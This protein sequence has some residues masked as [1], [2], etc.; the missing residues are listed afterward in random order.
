MSSGAP[1]FLAR[2]GPGVEAVRSA[3]RREGG[4]G[5]GQQP[6]RRT[7]P[8]RRATPVSARTAQRR[9]GRLGCWPPVSPGTRRPA[10]RHPAHGRGGCEVLPDLT[11]PGCEAPQP[12]PDGVGIQTQ[13][14]RDAAVTG[15]GCLGDPGF[16][17]RLGQIAAAQE[18]QHWHQDMRRAA[19]PTDRTP[20]PPSQRN[21]AWP[22]ASTGRTPTGPTG[23]D[24]TGTPT[25][26]RPARPRPLPRRSPP[27]APLRSAP[28]GGSPLRQREFHVAR[29]ADGGDVE[30]S[31]RRSRPCRSGRPP[32][33]PERRA[34]ADTADA[35]RRGTARILAVRPRRP[36]EGQPGRR[37]GRL[38]QSG[39]VPPRQLK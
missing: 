16:T 4:P 11:G 13:P 28:P 36:P 18:P 35:G 23:P 21:P 10:G 30:G 22:R 32:A 12:S 27:S 33:L 2:P 29:I 9:P 5:L 38:A 14:P 39:V 15:A 1:V 26:H 37:A 17:D 31:T 8:K 20:G 6:G 3:Q 34:P 25:G 24:T 19:R 7:L